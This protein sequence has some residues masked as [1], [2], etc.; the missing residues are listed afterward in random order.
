MTR[1]IGFV[2]RTHSSAPDPLVRLAGSRVRPEKA[3]QGTGLQA[4]G[5]APLC[6]AA[7][8]AI[9]AIT[10]TAA[11]AQQPQATRQPAADAQEIAR[12]IT[13]NG[14][15]ADVSFLASDALEGRG[16]PSRG[17]DVAAEFLAAQFRR[18]GL[19]PAGDDGYFQTANYVL[20]KPGAGAVDMTFHVGGRSLQVDPAR[21][22]LLL[23]SAVSLDGSAAEWLARNAGGAAETAQ[24]K[25]VLVRGA[26]IGG[27][28]QA[29][30]A[31]TILF[32]NDSS[33]LRLARRLSLQPAGE[34]TPAAPILAIWDDALRQQ[35]E[36]AAEIR[37]TAHIPPPDR[38]PVKLRNVAG[39]LRGADPALRDSYVA[40]TAHYDHMGTLPE[41]EGDRIYNGANDDASGAAT[42]VA[43]ANALAALPERPRRSILFIEFFGEELGLWGSRYYV[44]HPVVPLADTIADINLEQLGRTDSSEGQNIGMMNLTG[45]DFTT[46]PGTFRGAGAD[47]GVEVKN[48]A[49]LSGRYFAAS[50]NASFAAAGTPSTTASV[51]YEFP[52]YHGLGDEWPKLDYENMARVG[53][54]VTLAAR[55]LADS[56][57][58][59]KWNAANPQVERYIKA[60]PQSAR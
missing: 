25:V 23:P 11:E 49:A 46:L 9:A 43:A 34:T 38:A 16:T 35:L 5:P 14:L 45:F 6:L 54:A 42:V 17:L 53:C 12:L 47:C 1:S 8:V 4:R 59:P 40:V 48:D 30:A 44:G 18:A 33:V 57:D 36:G 20:L 58:L 24:G 56:A 28:G 22:G 27:P 29:G 7:L 55:R 10:V 26:L 13:A 32:A 60:A 51:T 2:G 50:D 31:M 39:I 37:V 52:D 15:K 41:G 21:M 19:Q 3:D